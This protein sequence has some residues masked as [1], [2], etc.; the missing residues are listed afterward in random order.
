MICTHLRL[1]SSEPRRFDSVLLSRHLEA[2]RFALADSL[3]EVRGCIQR[4]PTIFI[5]SQVPLESD[6]VLIQISIWP[7]KYKKCQVIG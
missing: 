3:L 1:C 7:P 6:D 2:M 4:L 5:V